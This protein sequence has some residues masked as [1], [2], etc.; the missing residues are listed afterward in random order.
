MKRI[1]LLLCVLFF[2]C[3]SS[4]YAVQPMKIV[5]FDS[6]PPRSW[7]ENGVMKGILID[8]AT[9]ALQNRMGIPLVHEGYPWARAQAMVERGLADAFI[10]VP[11]DAR[12]AYTDVSQS[13]VISFGLQIGTPLDS[14]KTDALSKVTRIEELKPYKIVD[15]YGNGWS[16]KKLK[17]FDVEWL[18]EL[19]AVY[20]FLAAGKA[21]VLL[22]SDRGI[23]DMKRLGYQDRIRLLPQRLN[24]LSFHL[25]IGKKSVHK[26]LLNEFDKVIND[27]RTDGTLQSISAKYY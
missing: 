7:K 23:Y 19:T 16:Q 27:M 15:Y 5:Y 11:T 8:I 10:T 14:K 25:C 1:L 13:A 2:V 26:D 22:L 20:P 3:S 12:R 6:Y 18:P 24:T 4:L 9:E 21:D 17:G